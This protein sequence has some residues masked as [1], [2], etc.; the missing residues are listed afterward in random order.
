MLERVNWGRVFCRMMLSCLQAH[1][2]KPTLTLSAPTWQLEQISKLLNSGNWL[3]Q[4]SLATPVE[5]A[6]VLVTSAN[7]RG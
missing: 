5:L 3:L 2:G 6:G 7:K 4:Q 1:R